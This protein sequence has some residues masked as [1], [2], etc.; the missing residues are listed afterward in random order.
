[1]YIVAL[2][3]KVEDDQASRDRCINDLEVF[4]EANTSSFVESLFDALSTNKYLTASV[5]TP[6][7]PVEPAVPQS[8]PNNPQPV[9]DQFASSSSSSNKYQSDRE[10]R[11]R[12]FNN[13]DESNSNNNTRRYDNRGGFNK[14]RLS[15]DYQE[16]DAAGNATAKVKTNRSRSRSNKARHKNRSRNRTHRGA[17]SSSSSSS[18]SPD[19]TSRRFDGERKSAYRR[20]Y[21]RSRSYSPKSSIHLVNFQANFIN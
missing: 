21:S 17:D 9:S 8:R 5:A 10:Q 13:Y 4:L 19:I 16:I 1:M 6:P 7:P 18:S 20:S 3:K 2:A 15:R 14:A 12:R 11:S